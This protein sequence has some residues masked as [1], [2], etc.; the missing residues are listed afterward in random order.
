M[1]RDRGELSVAESLLRRALAEHPGYLGTVE[2]LALVLLRQGV[3]A[4]DVVEQLE[5]DGGALSPT[6]AFLVAV[7]C[8]E[9]GAVQVAATLLRR[10]LTAQPEAHAARVILAEALL[11]CGDL[12][13]A[14]DEARKVPADAACA[15]AAART[16]LFSLLAAGEQVTDARLDAAQGSGLPSHEVAALRAWR[17]AGRSLPSLPATAATCIL[18]MLDALARLEAYEAFESLA[19]VMESVDRPLARAPGGDGRACTCGVASS[20][21]RPTSGSTSW[22]GRVPTLART[23]V[24]RRSRRPAAW[25]TTRA[26]WRRKHARWSR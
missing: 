12:A 7:A 11:S 6:G 17:D 18:T 13:A 16:E 26:C 23:R 15:Q 5:R 22:S 21:R 9:A 8:F 25:T 14:A 24:S 3:S 2:Q 1:H 4:A 10:T 19:A 20:S